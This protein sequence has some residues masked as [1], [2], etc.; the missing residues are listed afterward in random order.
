M[1]P[2]SFSPTHR[3][4]PRHVQPACKT[5]T[6]WNRPRPTDG[7][8]PSRHRRDYSYW[9]RREH[10]AL[11]HF[12]TPKLAIIIKWSGGEGG[13]LPLAPPT[14]DPAPRTLLYLVVSP[15]T[16]PTAT[17]AIRGHKKCVARSIGAI[18]N[19]GR[20]A[21]IMFT[22]RQD[23]EE[24]GKTTVKNLS[25]TMPHTYTDTGRREAQTIAGRSPWY[26]CLPETAAPTRRKWLNYSQGGKAHDW[27]GGCSGCWGAG[28]LEKTRKMG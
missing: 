25:K 15:L 8:T 5:L 1:P 4:P 21:V 12:P 23:R 2:S 24:A 20:K 14:P 6:P 9:G 27:L 13:G 18:Y 10:P 28:R 17:R 11:L 16:F 26:G 3:V 22:S 7:L 19:V